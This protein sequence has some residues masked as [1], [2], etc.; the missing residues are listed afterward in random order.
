VFKTGTETFGRT[1]VLLRQ[2]ERSRVVAFSIN[3]IVYNLIVIN[4]LVY[5]LVLTSELF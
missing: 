4:I 1:A 3:Y 2:I 5:I